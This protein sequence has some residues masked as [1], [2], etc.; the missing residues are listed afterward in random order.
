MLKSTEMRTGAT[1]LCLLHSALPQTGQIFFSNFKS[2][3]CLWTCNHIYNFCK[4]RNPMHLP[5][6]LGN[7]QP[8]TNHDNMNKNTIKLIICTVPA[9]KHTLCC[10]YIECNLSH[11]TTIQQHTTIP[12]INWISYHTLWL[13]TRDRRIFGN[14]QSTLKKINY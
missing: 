13:L 5:L 2:S 7:Q 6:F 9:F 1:H 8:N 11:S 14:I 3:V 12:E 10:N 4:V